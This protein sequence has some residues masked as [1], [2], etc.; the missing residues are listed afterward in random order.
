MMKYLKFCL[1]AKFT[2]G[3][4]P[5]QPVVWAFLQLCLQWFTEAWDL[6]NGDKRIPLFIGMSSDGG[7]LCSKGNK[8]NLLKL[9]KSYVCVCALVRAYVWV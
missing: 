3:N 7:T 8:E 1:D 6:K 4:P 5:G 2:N 9:F